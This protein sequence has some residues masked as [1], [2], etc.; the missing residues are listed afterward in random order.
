MPW[1]DLLVLG[2]LASVLLSQ[3]ALAAVTIDGID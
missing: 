3:P 1:R 2:L